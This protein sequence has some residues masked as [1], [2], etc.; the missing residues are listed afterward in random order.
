LT[1]YT[2]KNYA[3]FESKAKRNKQPGHICLIDL[4]EIPP[5]EHLLRI[6]RVV[7]DYRHDKVVK[8]KNWS[9]IP[10]WKEP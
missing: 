1:V 9:V 10:F 6:D 4:K 3:F 7:W 2:F 5:G 8:F